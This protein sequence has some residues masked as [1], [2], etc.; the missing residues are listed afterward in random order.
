MEASEKPQLPLDG[1]D[2][3]A[4]AGA[5]RLLEDR[6]VI[7]GLTVNDERAARVVRERAEAGQSPPQTVADAVE[8][9][10]RVLD[11]EDATVEVDYARRE[12]EAMAVT[13]REQIDAVN[14][15][16]VERVEA[17]LRRAFGSG[18]DEAGVLG[19]ALEVHSSGLSE[20]LAELFGEGR[21]SA[22]HAR[23]SEMLERRDR[24]FLQ[25]LSAEDELNPIRPL[26]TTLRE[27]A[28]ERRA[29]QDARD[30][31]L[32]VKLD[33]L[34]QEAAALAGV[35]RGNEEITAAIEAGTQKGFEFEDAVHEHIERIAS[36]RGDAAHHVGTVSNEAGS[37][38]GDTLV[39]IGGAGGPARARV[40]F[41]AKDK[42]LSRNDA[43][44]ELDAELEGRDACFAVLVVS[45]ESKLPARTQELHE[46]H[47]NKMV[48]AFDKESFDPLALELVYRYACARALMASEGEL[49]VDAAGVSAL[50]ERA[51]AALKR[52]KGVR[53]SLT[54]AE[55][56]IT[57]AR[58]GFDAIVDDVDTCLNQVEALIAPAAERS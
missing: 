10:A 6:L 11:R 2:P 33:Q 29:D 36:A 27:W 18:D 21:D 58:E 20:S 50:I 43:W 26:L 25:R 14:R 47:G 49:E 45:G 15:E 41:E 53:D 31:K 17:E 30:E 44:K 23:I 12:F 13:H 4:S 8:I 38:K 52:G 5:V 35:Q 39:E 57:G 32:E 3:G 56:G 46:Y 7:E 19:Q 1:G 48:V 22:V 40:I 24:E 37:K 34:L 51:A 42:K 9:G 55:Q 54:R 28:R 16:A